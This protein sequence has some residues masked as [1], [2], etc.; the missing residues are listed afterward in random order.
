MGLNL[1]VVG[2]PNVGKSTIFN[3]LT[4]AGAE[5]SNY[6]FC[7]IEPNVGVVPLADERLARLARIVGPERVVQTTVE[8]IDIAGLVKGSSSGEGLGNRFLGHIR[9]VDALVHVVRCF[10]DPDVA[11]VGGV[12]DVSS[13]IDI[14]STELILADLETVKKRL[15][16]A[17]KLARAG[18]KEAAAV[19][20]RLA[21][22]DEVLDSGRPARVLP[23]E[24]HQGLD[25][26]TSKPVLYVANTG[27]DDPLGRMGPAESV[28]QR[29]EAE[30]AAFATICGKVEAEIAE[31]PEEEREEFLK[32]VGLS[33]SGLVRLALVAHRLL[34]L[35]T[36]FT[37]TGSKE[38]RAW[39]ISH[40]TTVAEAAGRVHTDFE[41]GFVKA[42]VVGCD[43]FF[44]AGSEAACRSHGL[45]RVEGRDYV[46]KDGDIIHIR[47]AP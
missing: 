40:G 27:E 33:E 36:F 9:G 45:L 20:E 11:H 1:G 22:V 26:I 31:L 24:L 47:S 14:L 19:A 16:K 42:E 7:T 29:A 13:D 3:A 6:P 23:A 8:F 10:E 21:R 12:V 2:L 5:A 15:R 28:R 41:R 30:G 32:S 4:A 38:V 18:D 25:L 44:T 37:T 43:E 46:V 34:G 17:R 35:I 39:T